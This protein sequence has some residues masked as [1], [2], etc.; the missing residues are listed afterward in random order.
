MLKRFFDVFV[1]FCR[2]QLFVLRRNSAETSTD[3]IKTQ[4]SYVQTWWEDNN[5][6]YGRWV[7]MI[8][9]WDI[10][11]RIQ[12]AS[13][14][15][16]SVLHTCTVC[17]CL[18]ASKFKSNYRPFQ[19]LFSQTINFLAN[20]LDSRPKWFPLHVVLTCV[21]L[22][23]FYVYFCCDFSIFFGIFNFL[24]EKHLPSYLLVD[25]FSPLLLYMSNTLDR[26]KSNSAGI[27]DVG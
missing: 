7:I 26:E 27:M 13:Q 23:T 25:M 22:F 20:F 19:L 5:I 11:S 21:C 16:L 12:F 3:V 18:L 4:K 17:I 8:L 6:S 2:K 9:Q 24:Y 10:C 14:S 1:R 15:I